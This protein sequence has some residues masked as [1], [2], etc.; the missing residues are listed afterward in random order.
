[1]GSCSEKT[2][3]PDEANPSRSL[4][5]RA[6]AAAACCPLVENMRAAASTGSQL[7]DCVHIV[8]GAQNVDRREIISARR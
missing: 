4:F 6:H 2:S 3:A 8:D 1:M 5:V 7:T